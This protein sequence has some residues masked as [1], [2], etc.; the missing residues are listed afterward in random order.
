MPSNVESF[1][2]DI[3]EVDATRGQNKEECRGTNINAVK[4]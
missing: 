4:T 1:N 3:D 2:K